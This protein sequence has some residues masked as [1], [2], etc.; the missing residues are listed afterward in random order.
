MKIKW[1]ILKER[2]EWNESRWDD[3]EKSFDNLN[4]L[5]KW[6]REK[7]DDAYYINHICIKKNE[8]FGELKGKYWDEDDDIMT[9]ELTLTLIGSDIDL[10]ELFQNKIN[11]TSDIEKEISKI[12]REI[13]Q[14]QIKLK[15]QQEE[16]INAKTVPFHEEDYY[17]TIGKNEIDYLLK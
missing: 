12:E 15:E 11:L 10:R 3:G 1:N 5:Y 8:I 17:I 9:V 14:L 13:K 4:N 6:C 16:L 7:I 2:E